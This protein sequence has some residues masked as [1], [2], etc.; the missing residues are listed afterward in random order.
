MNLAHPN[1]PRLLAGS[2][3]PI[4]RSLRLVP[5]SPFSSP[6]LSLSPSL[7]PSSLSL[8][9]SPL[10]NSFCVGIPP[11]SPLDPFHA[12]PS[13]PPASSPFPGLQPRSQKP[14]VCDLEAAVGVLFSILI[15]SFP[16]NRSLPSLR[17]S[18]RSRALLSHNLRSRLRTA[19]FRR[20]C[21]HSLPRKRKTTR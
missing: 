15:T 10:I 2:L 12:Y 3:N 4:A 21:R 1:Q 16:K 9:S 6:S 20:S 17:R 13:V 11:V 7:L 5:P 18:V 8:A 19:S 14:C